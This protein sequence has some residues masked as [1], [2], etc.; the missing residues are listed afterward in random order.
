MRKTIITMLALTGLL[1]GPL[2]AEAAG[3]R[4]D[5][6]FNFGWRFHFGEVT[7]AEESGFN[8]GAW[9]Q[10]DLPHDFQIEQPWTRSGGANRGYKPL[11]TGWYRKTFR[12]DGAWRGKRVLLDFGGIVYLGDVWINGTK[13]ASTEYGYLPVEADL[14]KYLRWDGDNVVAVRASTGPKGG[15]RWYT[16]GGLFR[17]VR[18]VV[19]DSTAIARDGLFIT[20]PVAEADRATVA[21]Q[22]EMDGAQGRRARGV[23]LK[24]RIYAPS[25]ELVGE[26]AADVPVSKL[27]HVEVK[28]PEVNVVKP[29]RWSCETPRLYRAEVSVV[30]DGREIDR[31]S[32]EFGIRK[33][34][35]SP[36][37][38]MKLND[39]KVFIKGMAIHHDAGALGAAAFDRAAER[40]F[41]RMKEFGYNQIR[42]S[43][44]PYSD[45]FMRLA[46]KMGILVVDELIDKWSD[47]SYW[48]GR[49]PFTT[50]WPELIPTWIK[51][52]RNRASVMMWS[53]GN[54][55]QMR[56]DL[57]GY[58]TGDWGITTYRIFDVMVKR[59]DPTRK[60]TVAMF[61]ARAG[62]VSRH[63]ASFN[64]Y[65]VP[66]ELATVTDV[67]SF[68]YQWPVY[69]DY[70]KYAP[71]MTL[72]QSEATT[73][74]LAAPFF[75]MDYDR[76]V[77]L[78]YW[79]AVEYW[80]ES[81]GWPKK[82]W[83]YSF[84]SHTL[85]PKPQ[86]WLIKSAFEPETPVVRIGVLDN[87]E[88]HEWNDVMVGGMTLSSHWNR[89]SGSRQQVFTFTNADE[90]ELF[91]D[92]RSLGVKQNDRSN[93]RRRNVIVWDNVPYAGGGSIEAVARNA[94]KEVARHRLETAG[95]PVA[96]K[97]ETENAAWK[98]DGMDLQYIR[99][100]A[101]D[102]RGRRAPLA[103]NEVTFR[104][105]G[106]ATL[107]ATDNGNHYTD[108]VFTT[109]VRKMLNGF[110]MAI[111][112]ST[113]K[114]GKVKVSIEAAGLKGARLTLKTLP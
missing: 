41:K 8:D 50:L 25:G 61:P 111:L 82:G 98:A 55:L 52:D 57:A 84:F 110:D 3:V 13:V 53:L 48:G 2:P 80:G 43:H 92:G 72:Y 87:T 45:G 96:L 93:V 85:E 22:V 101:V 11:G 29:L 89:Q 10:I 106:E 37:F 60:T 40:L 35:F 69:K 33:I 18:L 20:T 76:M 44:N 42:T 94:G 103:D 67:S 56:E 78:S 7:G 21:L 62:A 49:K 71:Q 83:N 14:T 1:A 34:E 99:V 81:N 108:E 64:D 28:L 97:V 77:G 54:E 12:T 51:R 16:G 100:Y 17:D 73:N 46:D 104:V 47:K 65:L 31:V 107:L 15:S 4:T 90:V 23:Q 86:A 109:P 66:P 5:S 32:D 75:G 63:D 24:A 114:A 74:E 105:D 6:L 70:L 79:G 27:A 112:R 19:K 38:G 113:R 36:E 102:A 39:R 68:N 95:R 30:R 88:K 59:Y 58:P 9:R 26:T 91:V